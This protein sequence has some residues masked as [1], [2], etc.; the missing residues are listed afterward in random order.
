MDKDH[1]G[2]VD[3]FWKGAKKAVP[4]SLHSKVNGKRNVVM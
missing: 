3:G 2:N 4:G 1:A